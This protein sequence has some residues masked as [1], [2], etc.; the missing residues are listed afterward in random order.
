MCLSSFLC[1][2]DSC[3]TDE[4]LIKP[5]SKWVSVCMQSEWPFS[6]RSLL[7]YR[8]MACAVS[9]KQP[10]ARCWG[11]WGCLGYAVHLAELMQGHSV[12]TGTV[13][14]GRQE[15]RLRRCISL[16]LSLLKYT[17]HPQSFLLIIAPA[18]RSTESKYWI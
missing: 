6:R 3:D 17:F 1:F 18:V 16:L 14:Q 15:K 12:L 4:V 5:L 8:C 9:N 2:S 10:S 11:G 13:P 7:I